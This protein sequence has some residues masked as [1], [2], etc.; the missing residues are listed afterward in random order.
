[1]LIRFLGVGFAGVEPLPSPPLIK[2][3][4]FALAL[5]IFW[6]KILGFNFDS[7]ISFIGY[8]LAVLVCT[9]KCPPLI[10]G[11]VGR[12]STVSGLST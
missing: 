3:G 7:K 8:L 9:I 10:R 11:G 5:N 2:G 1:M 6:S 4:S 12:G